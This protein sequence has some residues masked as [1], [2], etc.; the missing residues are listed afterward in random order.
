MDNKVHIATVSHS[1]SLEDTTPVCTVVSSLKTMRLGISDRHEISRQR[2]PNT[3]V[4]LTDAQGIVEAVDALFERKD[5]VGKNC[6]VLQHRDDPRNTEGNCSIRFAMRTRTPVVTY[7]INVDACGHEFLNII[8]IVPKLHKSFWG[9]TCLSGF[10][11]FQCPMPSITVERFRPCLLSVKD[12]F[13]PDMNEVVYYRVGE[14]YGRGRVIN[15]LHNT[16]VIR[17]EVSKYNYCG[18]VDVWPIDYVAS[19]RQD[20]PDTHWRRRKSRESPTELVRIT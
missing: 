3:R 9:K 2:I 11:S 12:T 17:D 14:S 7:L 18:I 13:I 6:N 19:M 16:Y 4:I 1:L 5:V 20:T 10:Y 8:S 15:T